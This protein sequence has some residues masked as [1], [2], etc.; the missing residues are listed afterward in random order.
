MMM[1]ESKA[2][3]RSLDG[4][5]IMTSDNLVMPVDSLVVSKIV[6]AMTN[7]DKLPPPVV[8]YDGEVYWLAEGGDRLYAATLAGMAP[9]DC[10]VRSGTREDAEWHSYG[11]FRDGLPFRA[12]ADAVRRALRH[13]KALDPPLHQ[14]HK[15]KAPCQPHPP[16]AKG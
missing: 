6:A 9:I 10:E 2:E 1:N 3:F 14:V 13:R 7:G 11:A 4:S 16:P 12:T 15:Q 5:Q 8:Y